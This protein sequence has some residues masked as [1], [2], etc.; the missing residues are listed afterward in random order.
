MQAGALRNKLTI[1]RPV[2]GSADAMGGRA[3]SWADVI[4]VWGEVVSQ[5][6]REYERQKQVYPELTHVVHIRHTAEMT[7]DR[8]LL[9]GSP[10]L[11]VVSVENFEERGEWQRVV[12][13]EQV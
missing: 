8:R 11:D 2:A 9:F 6:G 13:K 10:V 5:G 4:D 3:I 1:Q 7:P 12:C